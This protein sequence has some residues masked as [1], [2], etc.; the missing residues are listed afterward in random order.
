MAGAAEN[1]GLAD[2]DILNTGYLIKLGAGLVAVI[3]LFIA[4]AWLMRNMGIGTVSRDG[5]EHLKIKATLSVGTRERIVLVEAGG[6]QVL[7]G[8][9]QGNI[10]TLHVLQN[11]LT[12]QK[13]DFAA[14]FNK[15]LQENNPHGNGQS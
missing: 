9:T 15:T 7:L 6:E 12:E 3:V 11:P 8:I 2:G 1:G 10:N 4:M 14:Q 13:K 5:M